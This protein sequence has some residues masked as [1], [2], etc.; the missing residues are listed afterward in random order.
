M[1]SNERDQLNIRMEKS[2]PISIKLKYFT[3]F[4]M[5]PKQLFFTEA[6]YSLNVF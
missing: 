1:T 2:F 3:K 6:Q 5:L 4:T